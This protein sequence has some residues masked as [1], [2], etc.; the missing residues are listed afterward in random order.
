MA[1]AD[2]VEDRRM[3]KRHALGGAGIARKIEA[4]DL[5]LLDLDLAALEFT[6]AELRT[7]EVCENADRMAVL[8]T[9]VTNGARKG[10]RRLVARVAHVDAEDVCS[11]PGR[12]ARAPPVAMTR[13]PASQ[14]S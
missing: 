9:H 5:A 12:G 7:L 8:G 13:V 4:E 10:A 1:F 2:G 3:G 11:R 6:E 14:Q